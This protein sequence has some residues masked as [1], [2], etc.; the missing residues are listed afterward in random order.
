[1][2]SLEFL[3]AVLPTFC[4][5]VGSVWLT[6][7]GAWLVPFVLDR[8]PWFR[9]LEA[10]LQQLLRSGVSEHRLQQ[11]YRDA[12]RNRAEIQKAIYEVHGAAFLAL[13]ATRIELH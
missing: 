13:A 1:M 10:D 7:E 9:Q 6:K 3:R 2:T 4:S 11:C 5:V 12:L 8:L